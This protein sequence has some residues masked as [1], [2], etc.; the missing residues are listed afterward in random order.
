MPVTDA[1][2]ERAALCDEALRAGPDAPTLCEGW[3]VRDL[4]VHLVVRDSRP[5]VALGQALPPLRE[6]ARRVQDELAALP[7]EELV[8]RVRRGPT[9]PAPTRLRVVDDLVNRAEFYVHHEDVRRAGAGAAPR[10]LPRGESAA[11]WKLVRTMGRFAYRRSGTG[12]VLVAPSGPRAV[13]RRGP[14]AVSLTGEPQELLLHA[15]GRR[16]V[17]RVAVD[18]SPDAV[19][20]FLA[21][22]PA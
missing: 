7:F 11:L 13:V 2:R 3:V 12:V 18:G 16:P 19:A 9:G 20:R 10:E 14:V 1:A 8:D 21:A 22:Y 15:F 5:D 6:H 4:L 17:A